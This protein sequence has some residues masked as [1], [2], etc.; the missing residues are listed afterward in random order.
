MENWVKLVDDMQTKFEVYQAVAKLSPSTLKTFLQFRIDFLKEELQEL[1]QST[2]GENTVDALIDLCIVAIGT[3]LIFQIDAHKAFSEVM[4][5]NMAKTVGVKPGRP[6]PLG[7]P[8]LVKPTGWV[9]PSHTGNHGL[10]G[11]I[12]AQD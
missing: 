10:L 6:N 1:E 11:K 12:H 4:R 9:G 8:D 5:A 3:L 2:D 7:L